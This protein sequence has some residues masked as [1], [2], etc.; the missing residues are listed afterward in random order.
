[1]HWFVSACYTNLMETIPRPT[2]RT[3][4]RRFFRR[5]WLVLVII[6]VL[7]A[8]SLAIIQWFTTTIEASTAQRRA[9]AEREIAAL[10]EVLQ[11]IIARKEAEEKARRLA[12]AT[13]TADVILANPSAAA[14]VVD[15]ADC[16]VSDVRRDPADPGVLVN[17]KHCI[18]PLTY[19][20]GDLVSV[21]GATISA[22]AAPSFE[23]LMNAATAAGFPLSV[24][25]SY[26]SYQ[27]QVSTYNY[28]VS[29][30]GAAGADTYS[31]RP[32]YSEHQ[33]GFA[34]DL[35]N[36]SGSCSLDCFGT[37]AE[38]QWLQ[39]NAA[40]Y[41]FI[42]RYYAGK[43]AV[44]GY[45]AEEWHY[46]YVG[47]DVALDMKAKGILTLEEYWGLPGGAY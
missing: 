38:Y 29:V 24:T 22:K 2:I 39:A 13:E 35:A 7:V 21:K 41:G 5:H 15:P 45:G 6:V 10:D 47:I 37:T 30:S 26:R 23:Q 43:D 40:T 4:I 20:P 16:N 27:T 17:K 19:A 18:Q 33:T 12:Q 44:T 11:Q 8:T 42:Q 32:G 31:A 3:S 9:D 34:V 14:S 25:S 46:R 28:W 1:M 36:A